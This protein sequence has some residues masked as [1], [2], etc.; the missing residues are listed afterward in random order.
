MDENPLR[1]FDR[2]VEAAAGVIGGV[3]AEQLDDPSPCAGWTVRQVINH[4]V[5]GNKMFM[6]IVAGGP[7]PDRSQDH[8]GDDPLAAF[9]ASAARLRAAFL[10]DGVMERSYAAPFGDGSGAKLVEMRVNEM[11]VHGWD[12]ARGSGQSTDLDPE[13]AQACLA[14]F[15]AVPFIPRGEGKPFGTERPV[16]PGATVADRLAAFTGRP[17]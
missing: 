16:P 12:V 15:E 5:T 6:S 17:V 3:K 1:L 8:L 11:I 2:A 13:V 4:L 10:T 9:R 7:P 14:L